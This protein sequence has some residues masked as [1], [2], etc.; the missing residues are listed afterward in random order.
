MA[1]ICWCS[2][3]YIF[4]SALILLSIGLRIYAGKMQAIFG[5]F[6]LIQM[7]MHSSIEL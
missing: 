5:T 7:I 3:Q 4:Y 1:I 6:F 2:Y